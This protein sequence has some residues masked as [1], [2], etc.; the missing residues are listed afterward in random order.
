[1][2]RFC[3]FECIIRADCFLLFSFT[4]VIAIVYVYKAIKLERKGCNVLVTTSDKGLRN[5]IAHAIE[6]T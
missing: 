4:A 6:D 5:H 1:M 2:F 3:L